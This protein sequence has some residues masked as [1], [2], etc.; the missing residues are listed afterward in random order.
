MLLRHFFCVVSI[1]KI[2]IYDQ[3]LKTGI[4]KQIKDFIGSADTG[5]EMDIAYNPGITVRHKGHY[6]K[7]PP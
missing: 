2:A 7:K 4:M 3:G 5:T 1:E 6:N